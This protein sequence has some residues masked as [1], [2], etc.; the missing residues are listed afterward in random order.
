MASYGQVDKTLFGGLLPGGEPL[1]NKDPDEQARNACAERG[2]TWDAA[3][4]TCKMPQAAAPTAE[5]PKQNNFREGEVITEESGKPTG[6]T[7][8]GNTFLGLPREDIQNISSKQQ[9][10]VAQIAGAPTVTQRLQQERTQALLQRL[11]QVDPNAFTGLQEA[12]IDWGQALT[13]GTIKSLPN[14]LTSAA[15]GAFVGGGVGA[16]GGPVGVVGGA[17]IGAIAG[18]WRGVSTN[19]EGQKKGEISASVDVLNAGRTNMRQLAMLASQDPANADL[20][21]AAYNQQL[22]LIHRA[23]SQIKLETQ[24]NLNKYIEDGTDILSDFELFLMAGGTADIYGQ[25]M[26]ISLSSGVP[27]PL[28]DA[29]LPE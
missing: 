18:I 23:H 19:I 24:G 8:G 22:S 9:A 3:T 15:G 25:K 5:S 13:A 16:A 7:K 4:K 6:I 10:E 28:T 17:I 21:I 26:I 1:I 12:P 11:G 20:Y 2:G 14:I 29:D 27:I